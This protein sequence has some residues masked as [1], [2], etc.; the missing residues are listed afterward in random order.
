MNPKK[1]RANKWK[2]PEDWEVKKLEEVASIQT[3]IQKGAKKN[4]ETI[5]LP[6]LRVANVQEDSLNLVEIKEIDVPIEKVER[7]LLKRGDVLMTEGGDFDKLG[8][9]TIWNNEIKRCVHQN[10]IFVVRPDP[11][12]LTETVH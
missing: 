9:G 11:R 1:Y 2:I 3:G 4:G 7:Y 5:R 10:H 6:Y 8:R 12:R